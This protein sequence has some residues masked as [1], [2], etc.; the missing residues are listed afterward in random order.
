M[1]RESC[2]RVR[3]S[4]GW[5]QKETQ[6][7]NIQSHCNAMSLTERVGR[8]GASSSLTFSAAFFW[9]RVV[10]CEAEASSCTHA[11]TCQ[12]MS[13]TKNRAENR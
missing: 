8:A 5:Q 6:K 7:S 4:A 2:E 11:R 12:R 10:T 9:W 13:G 3:V 1:R